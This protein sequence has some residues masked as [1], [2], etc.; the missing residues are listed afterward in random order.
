MW[1][2]GDGPSAGNCWKAKAV[3][4]YDG[5]RYLGFQIQL[6]GLTIQGELEKALAQIVRRPVR[7]VAAGRTDAG[8]HARG[9]VIHFSTAWK[10]P[11]R[12]LQ[13]AL[14]A[15]LPED[16]VVR[17]LERVADSFHARYS[18]LSREYRYTILNQP[19]PSPLEG[20][21][22]YHCPCPLQV[23]AMAQAGRGLLGGHDFASF[24]RSPQEDSKRGLAPGKDSSTVRQVYSL[25][26]VRQGPFVHFD[27]VA[28]AFLR[29]MV[30]TIVGTLLL[31]GRGKLS[32][33]DVEAILR[34]RDRGQSPAPLPARGLCLMKVNYPDN[35]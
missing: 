6:Q 25:T 20:R 34:A 12:D 4:E 24:G 5:T 27:I 13:R 28:N 2:A 15:L 22:A 29:R 14:N 19:W 31:V 23:E 18:A 3:I 32:A 21:F 17:E 8:V 35:V 11:V 33:A 10:H 1:E 7:V 16:I 9:Q 30:R 26:C